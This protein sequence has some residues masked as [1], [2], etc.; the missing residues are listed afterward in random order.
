MRSALF[1][2]K[3]TWEMICLASAMLA[4][5]GTFTTNVPLPMLKI[6][7]GTP[8]SSAV[9]A[10]RCFFGEGGRSRR[11]TSIPTRLCRRENLVLCRRENCLSTAVVFEWGFYTP[12]FLLNTNAGWVPLPHFFERKPHSFYAQIRL[13]LMQPLQPVSQLPA[14]P[15]ALS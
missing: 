8:A 7:R 15:P 9:G 3:P 14:R 1:Y 13:P 11:P 10:A 6:F 4:F 2:G 5:V 12:G